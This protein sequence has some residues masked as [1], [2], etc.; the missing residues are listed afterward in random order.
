[1]REIIT[2]ECGDCRRKNYTTT[3]NKKL[4]ADRLQLNKFCRSCR[5]YTAHKEIK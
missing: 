4:H 5:R 3:K 1:M 2:L